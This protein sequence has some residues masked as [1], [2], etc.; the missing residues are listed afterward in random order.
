LRLRSIFE[1]MAFVYLVS[2]GGFV[3]VMHLYA[4]ASGSTHLWVNM[5]LLGTQ[6]L[7]L[8]LYV[9]VLLPGTLIWAAIKAMDWFGVVPK[10]Q[11]VGA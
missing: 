9:G 3:A 11:E 2:S 7:E 8:L 6:E 4:Y 1:F 5:D 10:K